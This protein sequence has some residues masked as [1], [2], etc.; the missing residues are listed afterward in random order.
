MFAFNL[1]NKNKINKKYQIKKKYK[2]KMAVQSKSF[3]Y[4]KTKICC[5]KMVYIFSI[6]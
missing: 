3:L 1:K 6:I 5:Q 4:L 2:N